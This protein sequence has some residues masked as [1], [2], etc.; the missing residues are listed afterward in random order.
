MF[1]KLFQGSDD[2][3]T[4]RSLYPNPKEAGLFLSL[5]RQ[6]YAY[7]PLQKRSRVSV[8]FDFGGE[9][10]LDQKPETS[11]ETFPDECLFEIL[12][13]LPEGQYRSLCASVSK[14]WLMLM[15]SICK[16][17]ICSNV[18]TKNGNEDS[19]EGCLSRSLDGKKATDVRL[20][21]IVV[22]TSSRGGL[23]KLSIHRSNTDRPLTDVGLVVM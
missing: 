7:K 15:S 8:S 21:S 9:N 14:R 13:R 6:E 20:A 11:I 16:N 5:G 17:E 4:G 1:F 22:G 23:G 10:W 19:E 2:F 18:S 12:R 3:F